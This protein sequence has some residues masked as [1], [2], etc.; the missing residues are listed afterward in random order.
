MGIFVCTGILKMLQN[1][2]EI[3]C[4]LGHELAHRVLGHDV[5]NLSRGHLIDILFIAMAALLWLV[6]PSDLV[7]FVAQSISEK[8]LRV[9]LDLPFSRKME[10]EADLVGLELTAKAC[11]DVRVS[12]NIWTMMYLNN[13]MSENSTADDPYEKYFMTHPL[14]IERAEKLDANIPSALHIRKSCTC[15]PLPHEDPR[16]CLRLTR[17]FVDQLEDEELERLRQT[18]DLGE[19][20]AVIRELVETK[21]AEKVLADKEKEVAAI[22]EMKRTQVE[23]AKA[24]LMEKERAMAETNEVEKG[25]AQVVEV[26]VVEDA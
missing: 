15:P 17:A 22:E 4:V 6:L 11:Y 21:H 20:A 1:N 25:H 19:K 10:E 12:S 23:K 9:V 24:E 7:A 2:D 26:P 5:E 18:K 13:K 16:S 14:D 8:L 3:A